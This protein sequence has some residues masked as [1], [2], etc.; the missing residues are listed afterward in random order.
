M[1]PS[2]ASTLLTIVRA[3]TDDPAMPSERVSRLVETLLRQA[4]EAIL[5]ADWSAAAQKARS[6]LALLPGHQDAIAYLEAA[7]RTSSPILPSLH[8]GESSATNWTTALAGYRYPVDL[9]E[10]HNA[11]DG[12]F[13][14]KVEE[15]PLPQSRSRSASVHWHR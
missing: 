11:P 14:Y 3:G 12:F 6:V 8:T 10:F 4:E 2:C 9:R 13:D 7:E 15:I 1:K 5:Q